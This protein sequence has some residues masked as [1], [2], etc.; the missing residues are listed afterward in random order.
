MPDYDLNG[1]VGEGKAERLFELVTLQSSHHHVPFSSASGRV[2]IGG[3]MVAASSFNETELEP[4][5]GRAGIL[6]A[7]EVDIWITSNLYLN[8]LSTGFRSKNDV[9][10]LYRYGLNLVLDGGSS[11][12]S[13]WHVNLQNGGLEGA[14]DFFLKT[15][16]VAI[17]RQ[18]NYE[19]GYWLVG[20]G[21]GFYKAKMTTL[22]SKLEGQVNSILIGMGR[23]I[24]ARVTLD[25]NVKL[26]PGL[27]SIMVG[28][29]RS[30][31]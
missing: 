23:R 19:K 18:I 9:I 14:D 6:P 3:M 1:W 16:A 30:I 15:V 12:S 27:L 8:A 13:R 31:G 7:L 10:F 21:S 28:L 22:P 11:P 25:T 29:Y 4:I 5:R 20:L 24:G 2:V 17:T 26:N